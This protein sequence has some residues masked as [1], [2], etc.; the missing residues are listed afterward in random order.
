MALEL[1]AFWLLI[2]EA[3]SSHL[4]PNTDYPDL[5]VFFFCLRTRTD[6]GSVPQIITRLLR[7]HFQL[8]HFPTKI[9]VLYTK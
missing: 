7:H 5:E 1:V 2:R 3:S 4:G 9:T 8:D 6:S